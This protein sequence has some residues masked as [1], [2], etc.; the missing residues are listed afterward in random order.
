MPS[1]DDLTTA[2][3][4]AILPNLARKITV[5]WKG[6]FVSVENGTAVFAVEDGNFQSRAEKYRAEVQAALAEHFGVAVPIQLTVDRDVPGPAPASAADGDDDEPDFDAP[7]VD[8]PVAS[9]EDHVKMAF[10]GAEE[11]T[12]E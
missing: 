9:P 6:R 8:G 4:D 2:W 7:A 5:W 1:R 3:A 12:D 11:V 10:P